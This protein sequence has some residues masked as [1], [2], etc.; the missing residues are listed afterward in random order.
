MNAR[1][2]SIPGSGLPAPAL[3]GLL[4]VSVGLFLVYNG[5]LWRAPRE[6]SHVAR[7]AV[8]YLAVVPLAAGALLALRRLTWTHLVTSTG[9]V[10]AAKMVITAVLYQAFARGTATQLQAVAPPAT[11]ITSASRPRPT[12]YHAAASFASGAIHGR[13]TRQGRPV[14]GA[15][16]FL[17]APA[18]GRP[19]PAPGRVDLAIHASSYAAPLY[20]AHVDDE[21]RVANK[22]G[23]L[24][25]FHVSGAGRLPPN[26]PVPPEAE[27]PAFSIP[28]PGVYHVHCD[29]HPGESTWIV[30]VDHPYAVVTGDD[31]AFSLDGVPAGDARVSAVAASPSEGARRATARAVVT[32]S[33]AIDLTLDMDAAPGITR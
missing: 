24:H 25:T 28:D 18:A 27:S 9:V 31:G 8:S 23:A 4:T 21:I 7:F 26:R 12:E 2:E 32:A 3:L 33:G 13:V 14:A 19:A 15:V 5:L 11:A 1:R 10:W 6:A 22:D 17:D 30:V 16:V 20:L 29:N